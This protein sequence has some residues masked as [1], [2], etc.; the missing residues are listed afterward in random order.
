MSQYR[1]RYETIVGSQVVTTNCGISFDL[2]DIL[3]RKFSCL[4][5]LRP[6][7]PYHRHQALLR[8]ESKKTSRLRHHS[9][10][11]D[12]IKFQTQPRS[13][14]SIR[15]DSRVFFSPSR[16]KR[17]E[18]R[19]SPAAKKRKET[20]NPTGCTPWTEH[21]FGE[22]GSTLSLGIKKGTHRRVVRVIL[23]TCL[24]VPPS[25]PSEIRLNA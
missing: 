17:A 9:T 15:I 18:E 19:T 23:G 10:L 21:G 11:R 24:C 14:R 16:T 7:Q 22:K 12:A 3:C 5:V 1:E 25:P 8:A 2:S 20:E 4:P 6:L 13:V